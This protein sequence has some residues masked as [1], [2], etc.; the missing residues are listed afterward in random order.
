MAL[1]GNLKS[2]GTVRVNGGRWYVCYF[3]G[4]Y[5]SNLHSCHTSEIRT[6]SAFTAQEEF[7]GTDFAGDAVV[8]LLL[9]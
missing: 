5:L 9:Q 4:Q 6:K 1:W 2:A 8:F 7:F 3:T